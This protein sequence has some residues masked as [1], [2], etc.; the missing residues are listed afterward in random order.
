M[1]DSLLDNDLYKFCMQQAVCQLYPNAEAE[2]TFINRGDTQF[3]DMHCKQLTNA[4]FKLCHMRFG[5]E[6]LRWLSDTCYFFTPVYLDFLKSF[7][8]RAEDVYIGTTNG[9]L[10]I[11]IRG[12]WYRTILWEV[13]L[14]AMVSE[15]YYEYVVK[16]D[17]NKLLARTKAKQKAHLMHDNMVRYADF[18]TRR[19]FSFENH[20]NVLEVMNHIGLIGTSNVLLAKKLGLKPIGTQAHEWFMFHAAKDGYRMANKTALRAWADVYKGS[21]GIALGDTFTTKAFL[22]AFDGELARLFDGVRQDSGDPIKIGEMII[23]H[24]KKLRINP[25]SKTI[26]FSDALTPEKAVALIKH[27]SNRI[28]V[29]FGIGTNLTNDVG[30]DPLNIVIKMTACKPD[31][32]AEWIP[33]VKLSDSEGKYTGAPKEIEYAKRILKRSW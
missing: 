30:Y 4:I 8:F 2:Y 19:R 18:G 25:L 31:G 29:S 1:L 5:D 21:L 14:L 11:K 28:K 12:P 7:Q 6:E 15:L 10:E 23:E 26:I 32:N 3:S 17:Y 24:Y 16:A 33:T 22:R 20:K 27:F 9:Q 13:P